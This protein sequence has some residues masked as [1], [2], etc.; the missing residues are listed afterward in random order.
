MYNCRDVKP[1]D[2]KALS[3]FHAIKITLLHPPT[4]FCQQKDIQHNHQVNLKFLF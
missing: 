1:N 3:K 2:M 4:V